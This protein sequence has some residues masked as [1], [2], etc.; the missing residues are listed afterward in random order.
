MGVQER[1]PMR[2]KITQSGNTKLKQICSII[3]QI[4]PAD[5]PSLPGSS[6][7]EDKSTTLQ[8]LLNWSLQTKFN[9]KAMKVYNFARMLSLK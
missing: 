8:L 6:L 4:P 2:L 1:V 7:S 3:V 9:R 5:L